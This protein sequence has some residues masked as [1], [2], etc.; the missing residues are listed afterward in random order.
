MM[1]IGSMFSNLLVLYSRSV[2]CLVYC[3]YEYSHCTSLQ[4]CVYV[5]TYSTMLRTR[6]RMFVRV[7]SYT[8]VQSARGARGRGGRVERAAGAL[9]G[10]AGRARRALRPRTRLPAHAVRAR[11][12]LDAAAEQRLARHR[13]HRAPHPVPEPQ[14]STHLCS[15][16][17]RL[18]N[19]VLV[20]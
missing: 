2:C 5:V 16:T 1:C 3:T 4:Q 12:P 11:A 10:A 18:M 7:C 17:I 19:T 6:I 13:L 20:Q 9:R 15:R 8:R 14:P